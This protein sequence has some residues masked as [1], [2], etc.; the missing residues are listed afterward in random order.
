MPANLAN[1]TQ[2]IPQA[3]EVISALFLSAKF[4]FKFSLV[5]RILHDRL[6]HYIWYP[7][8]TSAYAGTGGDGAGNE[9]QTRDL[10]LGNGRKRIMGVSEKSG[11]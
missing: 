11:K 2:R 3:L 7:Q 1:K 10:R 5:F 8:V 6:A 9:T 4:S